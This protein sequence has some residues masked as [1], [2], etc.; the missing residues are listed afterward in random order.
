MTGSGVT[1]VDGAQVPWVNGRDA[2]ASMAPA[3]RDNLGDPA[4][5]DEL[6]SRY[7]LRPLWAD[8]ASS[9]RI[10]HVRTDPGYQ[11]LSEAFHDSVEEALFLR[12]SVELT[13]EGHLGAGDYFWRPPGWIHSAASGDGFECILMMEG[14][15]AAEGSDRVSRVVRADDE[16]GR[17]GRPSD[18]HEERIGPRGYVRRLE[19]GLLPLEEHEDGQTRLVPDGGEL[20]RSRVL[21]RNALTRSASVL[22]AVPAGWSGV[23]PAVDR[24]R[25]LVLVEGELAVDRRAVGACSLVRIAPGVAGPRLGSPAGCRLLVKVGSPR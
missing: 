21:S 20:L 5:V 16:A 2:F 7:W 23:V 11:D 18:E 12:G 1:V 17:Y 19:T 10:D 13:A 15:D 14:E 8:A 22:V 24:E 4:R 9:R 3:F 25:F 6:L